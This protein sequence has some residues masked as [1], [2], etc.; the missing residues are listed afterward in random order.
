M[1]SL[2]RASRIGILPVLLWAV[3][4]MDNS[5]GGQPA[6]AGES[7]TSGYFRILLNEKTEISQGQ[8]TVEGRVYSGE[9]PSLLLWIEKA[10]SGACALYQPRA[11]FCN[12]GCGSGALCVSDGVCQPFAEPIVVGKVTLT[13]AKTQSGA[14][15]F[16]MD[17][18]SKVYQPPAGVNLEYIPFAEG[19][20]VK[21]AAAGDSALGSFSVSAKAI[22]RLAVLNDSIVLN[23]GQPLLLR[24]TPPA[25]DIGST[26]SVLIDVS[27]HGGSKGKIECETEDDG[28]LDIPA[29]LVDA[30]KALGV[31]GWPQIEFTRKTVGVNPQVHVNLEIQSPIAKILG[32]PG[33][34][35][36]TGDEHCPTGKTCQ[37]DLQCK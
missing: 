26:L 24:W 18:I 15:S 14:V 6:P 16:T 35:S 8:P 5:T 20:E 13:G 2:A 31:S 11:P 29:S 12:P 3:S 27:H 7:N 34:I 37:D 22:A 10:R 25:R 9:S 19:D 30:L 4:C 1:A 33:L 23:D 36:C 32:I 28:S 17:P 21:V